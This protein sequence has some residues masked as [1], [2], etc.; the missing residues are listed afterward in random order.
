MNLLQRWLKKHMPSEKDHVEGYITI[1][2]SSNILDKIRNLLAKA[3]ESIHFL[4]KK[5]PV[6]VRG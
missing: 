4:Y 3:E 6:I 2:G 5:L 1:E